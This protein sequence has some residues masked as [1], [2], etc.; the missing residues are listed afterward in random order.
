MLLLNRSALVVKPKQP[1]LDWLYAADPTS[2]HLML[3]DLTR[4]PTVYLIPECDTDQDVAEVLH[5]FYD[6]IFTD[7]LDGWYRDKATWPEDRSYEMFC[8]WF[9]FQ[10]HSMLVDLGD[11][12]LICE[13]Y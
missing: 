4:E 10:H 3:G 13:P 7:K 6:D 11:D 9:D 12:P 8:Q 1:F 2:H 5:E